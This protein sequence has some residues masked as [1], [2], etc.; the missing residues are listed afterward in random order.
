MPNT[1]DFTFVGYVGDDGPQAIVVVRLDHVQPK[2]LA[3]GQFQLA[4]TSYQLFRRVAQDT[5]LAL[6]LPAPRRAPRR[7]R[8]APDR[9][10]AAPGMPQVPDRAAARAT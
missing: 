7:T 6:D 1:F 10:D 2:V 8:Q 3:Q 4:I 5:I 9:A